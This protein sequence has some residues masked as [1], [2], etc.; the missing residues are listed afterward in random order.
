MSATR[1]A[2][3]VI[4]YLVLRKDGQVKWQELGTARDIDNA[5]SAM[6]SRTS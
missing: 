2:S 3:R 4:L 6:R 1:S 5:I